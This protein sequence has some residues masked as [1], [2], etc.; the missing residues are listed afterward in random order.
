M[1]VERD[2]SSTVEKG[3]RREPTCRLKVLTRTEKERKEYEVAKKAK[4]IFFVCKS[5]NVK[6]EYT[7]TT[8]TTTAQTALYFLPEDKNA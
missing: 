4:D 5:T 6:L 1:E 8:T 3:S 7:T 2:A